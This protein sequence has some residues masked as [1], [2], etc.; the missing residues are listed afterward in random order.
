[1]NPI[2]SLFR[3]VASIA[4]VAASNQRP[5]TASLMSENVAEAVGAAGTRVAPAAVCACTIA[6]NAN[7]ALQTIPTA[8]FLDFMNRPPQTLEPRSSPTGMVL[9]DKQTS[10]VELKVWKMP[11]K[12]LIFTADLAFLW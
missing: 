1:M 6:G 10:L 5:E 3:F 8:K 7:I 11:A 4:V 2:I 12:L 9:L